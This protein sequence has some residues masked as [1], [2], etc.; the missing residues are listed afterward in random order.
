MKLRDWLIV[1]NI[2][3]LVVA[4]VIYSHRSDQVKELKSEVQKL[5][6]NQGRNVEYYERVDYQL[7]RMDEELRKH[8]TLEELASFKRMDWG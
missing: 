6:A 2:I 5:R 4:V 1:I 3:W 7:D 8:I